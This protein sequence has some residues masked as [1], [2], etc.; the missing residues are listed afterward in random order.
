M[1]VPHCRANP[2]EEAGQVAWGAPNLGLHLLHPLLQPLVQQLQNPDGPLRALPWI[3][4]RLQDVGQDVGLCK[5]PRRL[6]ALSKLLSSL[7]LATL[8]SPSN[9]LLEKVTPSTRNQ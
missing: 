4:V 3:P 8:A 6:L 1:E 7:L 9:F 5:V 2:A